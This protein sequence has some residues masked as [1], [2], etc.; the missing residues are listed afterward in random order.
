VVRGPG[1]VTVEVDEVVVGA[2]GAAVEV[3][4]DEVLDLDE[5]V[6]AAGDGDGAL[7]AEAVLALGLLQQRAEERVLEVAQR[8][9]EPA[10]LVALRA[11]AHRHAPLGH[12]RVLLVVDGRRQEGAGPGV[13]EG[14]GHGLLHFAFYS[15]SLRCQASGG[16][17]GGRARRGAAF[18]A[19]RAQARRAV[20]CG[21]VATARAWLEEDSVRPGRSPSPV[22]MID[23][24]KSNG[25]D[26]TSPLVEGLERAPHTPVRG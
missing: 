20:W 15:P 17:G 2:G 5:S 19:P 14:G 1:A 10:L 9:G 25:L 26:E 22:R 21:Q 16:C 13:A 12:H 4:V 3:L 8:H 11:H 6:D 23:M 24:W 18:I 7:V